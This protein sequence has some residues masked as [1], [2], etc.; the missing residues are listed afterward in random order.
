[1][2]EDER[3]KD[4]RARSAAANPTYMSFGASTTRDGAPARSGSAI[5]QQMHTLK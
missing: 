3:R 5:F 4:E 2:G 1:M